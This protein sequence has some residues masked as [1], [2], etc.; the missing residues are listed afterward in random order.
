MKKRHFPISALLLSICL[1]FVSCGPKVTVLKE[2][3][4]KANQ[5]ESVSY[6]ANI[7]PVK[8]TEEEQ[9]FMLDIL[10]NANA[11]PS[12]DAAAG[13]L[14]GVSPFFKLRLKEQPASFPYERDIKFGID[15]LEDKGWPAEVTVIYTPAELER[16][17]KGGI[18]EENIQAEH[19]FRFYLD[20]NAFTAAKYEKLISDA[21][22]RI[23]KTTG[24]EG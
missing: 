21:N 1:L 12:Q 3:E 10:E 15:P 5:V 11:V 8:L 22:K 9:S 16:Q 23:Q 7:A 2:L 6:L 13:K 19:T 4:L 17:R 18:A 24:L 14:T 20:K